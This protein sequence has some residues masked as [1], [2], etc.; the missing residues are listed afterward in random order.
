M[1]MIGSSSAHMCIGP[2]NLASIC[3]YSL[4]AMASDEVGHGSVSTAAVKG[5]LWLYYNTKR[6]K[7]VQSQN[8]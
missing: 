3:I 5:F 1:I 6:R 7:T 8:L 4:Q 2:R